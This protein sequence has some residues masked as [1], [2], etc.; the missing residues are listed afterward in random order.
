MTIASTTEEIQFKKTLQK[1]S[2]SYTSSAEFAITSQSFLHHQIKIKQ[3]RALWKTVN[4]IGR[5]SFHE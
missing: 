5:V 1:S 2:S 4:P 3:A